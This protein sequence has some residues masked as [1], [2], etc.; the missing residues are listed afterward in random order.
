MTTETTGQTGNTETGQTA[1]TGGNT[2][3]TTSATTKTGEGNTGETKNGT[4]GNT[5]ETKPAASVVPEK[6]EF[7]MA[8][9]LPLPKDFLEKYTPHFK[10]LNLSNESAQKVTE[11]VGKEVQAGVLAYQEDRQQFLAKETQR[12]FDTTKADPEV[13]GEKFASTASSVKQLV[14]KF[15]TPAF[16]DALN[17]TGLGNHP[18]LVRF[19]KRVRDAMGNDSFDDLGG[20]GH[21]TTE[22]LPLADRLYGKKSAA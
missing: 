9:G 4:E 20:G 3:E 13:G 2:G 19:C 8:E 21:Q 18:E 6:Y 17:E 16:R 11:F 22:K 14:D 12:W 7:S 1:I 15:G 10:A 5:G